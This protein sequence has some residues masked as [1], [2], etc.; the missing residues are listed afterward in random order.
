M[1]IQTINANTI[2]AVVIHIGD[3]THHHDQSI[4]PVNFR[5]INKTVSNDTNTLSEL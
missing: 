1:I 5:P 3:N 4:W 2:I